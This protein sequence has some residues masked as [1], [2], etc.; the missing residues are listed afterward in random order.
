MKRID[1]EHAE[2]AAKLIE[3]ARDPQIAGPLPEV[4]SGLYDA[5]R[6]L[7][8][9]TYADL[10]QPKPAKAAKRPRTGGTAIIHPRGIEERYGISAVTR[11]RWE[12]TGKLPARDVFIGGVASGWR[13]E[14]L[15]AAER[16]TDA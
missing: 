2:L 1:A 5:A 13:P 8:P 16:G 7:S 15:E 12:R 3:Y 6:K 4:A 14:T 10:T 11:Y 9:K